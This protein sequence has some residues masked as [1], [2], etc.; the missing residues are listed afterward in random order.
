M[1]AALALALLVPLAAIAAPAPP[2]ADDPQAETQLRDILERPLFARTRKPGGGPVE[3]P[4]APPPVEEV[5]APVAEPAAGPPPARVIGV[6]IAPPVR[7]AL[8]RFGEA[9]PA[10]VTEGSS[11]E[12]WTVKQIADEGVVITGTAGEVR[13]DLHEPAP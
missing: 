11:A 5:Q 1:R 8:L 6:L 13:L 10:W 12:G 4:P 9:T 2:Q 7:K 3:A